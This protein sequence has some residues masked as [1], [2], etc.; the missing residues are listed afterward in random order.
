MVRKLSWIDD[1]A[2]KQRS[3]VTRQQLIGAHYSAEQIAGLLRSGALRVVRP[4]VYATVGSVRTWEQELLARVLA[5]GRGAVASHAGSARLWEWVHRPEDALPVLI[6]ADFSL[7]IRGVRRTTIL[8]D[9]DVTERRGIPCTSFERTLCDC[10]PLLSPFQLG[11]V[12]DDGLRRGVASLKQLERCAVRL[13]SGRGRRLTVVK[14]LLAQRDAD[15]H[16]GGSGSELDVLQVIR[17]AGLPLPVQQLAVEVEGRTFFP[18]YAWPERKVFAEYYGLAHHSGASAV[19]HDN[20]RLS[21]L[22]AIGWRPLVFD[23][24]TSERTMVARLRRVLTRAAPSDGV[25]DDRLSA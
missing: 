9:D 16:P 5:V 7:G 13:D 11:R 22:V 15:F 6:K 1:I 10:T 20:D 4:R 18:D 8:P 19:A 17:D 24:T 12:L 14:Q 3:L 23:E 25:T 21:A 2:S